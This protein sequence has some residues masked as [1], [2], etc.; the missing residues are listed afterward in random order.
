MA[1]G[2]A[3]AAGVVQIRSHGRVVL[4]HGAEHLPVA[5]HNHHVRECEG[6]IEPDVKRVYGSWFHHSPPAQEVP[7]AKK[8]VIQRQ[9]IGKAIDKQRD[10]PHGGDY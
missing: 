5:D 7:W 3:V 2:L 4:L 1:D 6:A 9:D 10:N 8:E